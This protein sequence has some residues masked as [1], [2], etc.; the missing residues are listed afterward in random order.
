MTIASACAFLASGCAHAPTHRSA[1]T[2][3]G[4]ASPAAISESEAAPLE[5]ELDIEALEELERVQQARRTPP[6]RPQGK[7]FTTAVVGSDGHTH[8]IDIRLI[9]GRAE[10]R[11]DGRVI[12]PERVMVHARGLVEILDEN[13]RRELAFVLP[14]GKSSVNTT[15][16]R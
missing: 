10:T 11:V 7:P 15:V 5:P 9:D 12:P 4:S 16:G 8:R 2:H 13:G 3:H 1:P 6:P 14:K